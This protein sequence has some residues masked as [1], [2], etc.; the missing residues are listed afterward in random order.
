M[1][2]VARWFRGYIYEEVWKTPLKNGI[3]PRE[4]RDHSKS[5]GITSG[6][7]FC[8]RISAWGYHWM[9]RWSIPPLL[10]PIFHLFCGLPWKVSGSYAF[11]QRLIDY[12][13]VLIATIRYLALNPSPRT[14]VPKKYISYLG[15][16]V[17]EQR[18]RHVRIDNDSRR[19]LIEASSHYRPHTGWI[20]TI[21][22]SNYWIDWISFPVEYDH[23][24]KFSP[25]GW[26]NLPCREPVRYNL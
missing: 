6:W 17:D 11:F 18:W 19:E 20:S 13:R 26:M 1:F 24:I 21:I 8:G 2:V 14:L 15:T 3:D 4:A 7:W 12:P 22:Y 10:P 25:D 5:L 23:V 9:C 16:K